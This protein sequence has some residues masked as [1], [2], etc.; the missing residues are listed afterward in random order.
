MGPTSQQLL[1]ILLEAMEAE[2]DALER[3]AAM[4]QDEATGDES[5]AENKYDTRSLEASYLARG[6]AERVV[7]LRRLCAYLRTATA[8]EGPRIGLCS[9][10]A[11]EAEDG[12]E[13]VAVLVPD[14]GGKSVT[15]GGTKVDVITPRS[16]LGR[17]LLGREAGDEV[18][19]SGGS[20]RMTWE[21]VS[22]G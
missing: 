12:R 6:Q 7:A 13:R 5:R 22:V 10:V 1:P 4:A 8:S 19:V 14:G 20:G 17:A 9:V 3:V 11:L 21:I 2:R 15:V 18:Q 16:P